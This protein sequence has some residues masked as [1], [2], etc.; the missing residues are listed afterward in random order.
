MLGSGTE[1]IPV[2][3]GG[4]AGVV[5][6]LLSISI[7]ALL[8]GQIYGLWQN[9]TTLESFTV[10]IDKVV[11]KVRLSCPFKHQVVGRTLKK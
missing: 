7:G 1:M 11:K 6:L 3:V 10:G 2:Y 8:G 9:L 5:A 4:T